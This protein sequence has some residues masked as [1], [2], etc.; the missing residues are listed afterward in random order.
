M[1]F[2]YNDGGRSKY[3]K[4]ERVGDCVTRA[5]AIAT[6]KDY[7]EVYDDINRLSKASKSK[8]RSS[9][10]NGVYKLIYRK[11]LSAIGWEWH[12]TCAVGRGVTMHLR[13]GEIPNG[14]L[15]L[16]LAH[17]L[18]CVKDGVIH[19]TWDCSQENVYVNDD[20]STRANPPAV[21]GYWTRDKKCGIVLS[22]RR[23]GL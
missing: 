15:I 16:R 18:V 23:R 10:R 21:Y 7:K 6:G 2:V 4:A 3:F 1:D 8:L 11:Y 22:E 20:G 9:A 14:T 17:H 12:S 13:D 5:I 19:D